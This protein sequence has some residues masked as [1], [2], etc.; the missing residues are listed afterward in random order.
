VAIDAASEGRVEW[1]LLSTRLTAVT[2]FAAV[3]M[4]QAGVAAALAGAIAISAA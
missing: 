2:A 4:E 1:A 3:F